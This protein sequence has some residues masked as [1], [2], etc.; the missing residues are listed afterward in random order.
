M[1]CILRRGK[2]CSYHEC[3][4][5][6]HKSF[7]INLS[8]Y[9]QQTNFETEQYRK[10][11][12][13]LCK[14]VSRLDQIMSSY[15]LFLYLFSVPIVVFLLY[16]LWDYTD[17]E[18]N[19]DLTTIGINVTTLVFFVAL[20]GCVTRAGASLAIAV[21]IQANCKYVAIRP[22]KIEF[23]GTLTRLNF[24]RTWTLYIRMLTMTDYK[25]NWTI[26]SFE[27]GDRKNCE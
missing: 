20:L 21:S 23:N 8:L 17:E 19:N 3:S 22:I 16:G 2:K 6:H 25:I 26:Q 24:P 27:T 5:R 18:Y 12:V 7:H 1:C 9:R 14:L 11:H 10:R 13:A 15:L 4:S